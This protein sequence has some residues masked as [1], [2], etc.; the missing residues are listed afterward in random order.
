MEQV[1]S[2]KILLSPRG[3]VRRWKCDGLW[4]CANLICPSI[5]CVALDKVC[6]LNLCEFTHNIGP[7]TTHFA[8][9]VWIIC[10]APSLCLGCSKYVINTFLP[11]LRLALQWLDSRPQHSHPIAL[12]SSFQV[13]V[14]DT[15]TQQL[16]CS[17]VLCLH[18]TLAAIWQLL[19]WL[20]EWFVWFVPILPSLIP[21]L[22]SHAVVYDNIN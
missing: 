3:C 7:Y 2:D 12:T 16:D 8:R 14:Y 19:F 11:L 10:Q 5:S 17:D 22:R 21:W 9:L 20:H 15:C 1:A 13:S 18:Y 6:E 4:C